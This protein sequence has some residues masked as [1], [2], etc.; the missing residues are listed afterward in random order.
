MIYG[1]A[2]VM[3]DRGGVT[4]ASSDRIHKGKDHKGNELVALL[5]HNF[6]CAPTIIA[7]RE[8]WESCLPVPDGL[9][10]HDW[11]FT[12][13]MARRHEFYYFDRI[14]ADYRVHSGNH[15][16]TIVRDRTEE[17]SIFRMLDR[18]FDENEPSADV[19]AAKRRARRRIYGAQYLT[20]ANKYFGVGM[21]SDARRCYRAAIRNR[22]LYMLN[23]G[24]QRRLAATIVGRERYELGKALVRAVLPRTGT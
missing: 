23:P 22:P 6:I 4:V 13:S 20:L 2:A 7:R 15:H 3:N 5:E 24:V 14:L 11:Y 8:A 19:E 1:N 9:A 10:F 21:N 16:A 18:V 12:V 17:P